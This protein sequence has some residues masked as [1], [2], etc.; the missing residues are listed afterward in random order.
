MRNVERFENWLQLSEPGDVIMY[1]Q[2]DS[3]AR[4]PA[5]RRVFYTAAE[6]GLV[7]L[8]QKRVRFG[9][10][11]YYAKRLSTEAGR[12]LKPEGWEYE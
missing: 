5:V 9:V 8:Y 7:F 1:L 6:N 12:K 2:S 4:H 10:F 11:N 3:A